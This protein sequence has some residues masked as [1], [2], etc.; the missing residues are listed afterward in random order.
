MK[1]K[2]TE[3]QVKKA[4][5]ICSTEGT[6]CEDCPCFVSHK[7]SK[8]R[9]ALKD[10]LEIINNKDAEI[11]ALQHNYEAMAKHALILCQSNYEKGI[12]DF[13]EKL[14]GYVVEAIVTDEPQ[15]TVRILLADNIE[16]LKREM[17]GDG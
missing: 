6:S 10:A 2:M 15:K 3:D 14:N 16:I 9:Q 17:M 13:T 7:L 12:K 5:E 4:L 8:C 11:E 1:D